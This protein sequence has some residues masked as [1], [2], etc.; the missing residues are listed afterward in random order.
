LG[1]VAPD[2][3]DSAYVPGER[4]SRA[5]DAVSAPRTAATGQPT[6]PWAL[7]TALDAGVVAYAADGRVTF[8][9]EYAHRLFGADPADPAAMAA[10]AVYATDGVTRL[11]SEALRPS[12][13]H[14]DP[15]GEVEFI[16]APDGASRRWVRARTS[17]VPAVGGEPGGVVVVLHDISDLRASELALR[18]ARDELV[19]TNA[20]LTRSLAQVEAYAGVVSHDLKSPLVA[21]SGYAQLLRHLGS[22][23]GVPAEYNEFLTE[24]LRGVD[25]MRELVD[26]HLAYATAGEGPVERAYVDLAA[27]VEEVVATRVHNLR[28]AGETAPMITIGPLPPVLGDAPMLRQVV[29]NLVGNAVKYTHP[30]QA[31]QVHIGAYPGAAGWVYLEVADR[32]IGIPDDQRHAIFA[33][34]HRAHRDGT[35]QGTG[36]GLAICQRIVQRHGGTI[37]CLPNPGGGTRFCLTLPRAYAGSEPTVLPRREAARE[38][39]A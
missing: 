34:F 21:V 32:G 13:A 36:L 8:A 27:L 37:D 1:Q 12:R 30:G 23:D 9:N 11:G 10:V 38:V 31:A 18:T 35:Y 17:P 7:F 22:V 24:I 29:D 14:A 15:G 26:G 33:S 6:D 16:V 39:A 20:E 25:T 28:Q 19:A 4:W 2:D 5:R 3:A